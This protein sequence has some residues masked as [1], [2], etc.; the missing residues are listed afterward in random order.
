[1]SHNENNAI[2]K[3]IVITKNNNIIKGAYN[4]SFLEECILKFWVNYNLTTCG[5]SKKYEA[6]PIN[7][8]VTPINLIPKYN[9]G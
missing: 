6:P 3:K 5:L 7:S 1:M 4:V 2:I 8:F 9:F